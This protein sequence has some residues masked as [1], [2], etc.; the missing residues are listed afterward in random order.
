MN[1]LGLGFLGIT[2]ALGTTACGGDSPA[3]PS[4]GT[5]TVTVADQTYPVGQVLFR[6]ALGEG[7]YFRL[8]G[9][10]AAHPDDDCLPGLAGGMALYGD[11]P[12]DVESIADLAGRELPFEFSGDGDDFNLCFVGSNGL[13]GVEEGIVTFDSVDGSDLQF[14][15]AGSFV[16]YDG[17]GGES[18]TPTHASG[19]GKARTITY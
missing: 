9:N 13:L 7:G 10:D 17:A 12:A 18:A 19:A 3:E 11:M 5:A 16:I 8:E 6:Y 1:R 15:F 14:S 4:G 2:L